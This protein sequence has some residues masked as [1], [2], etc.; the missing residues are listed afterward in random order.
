MPS[1]TACQ[2]PEIYR[3]NFEMV[4]LIQT[5]SG[6]IKPNVK[7]WLLGRIRV[8]LYSVLQSGFGLSIYY[9]PHHHVIYR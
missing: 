5:V 9:H 1:I 8:G 2:Y 4:Y 3:L 6:H 7:G